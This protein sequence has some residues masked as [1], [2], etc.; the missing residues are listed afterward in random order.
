MEEGGQV[1]VL[2]ALPLPKNENTLREGRVSCWSAT[3]FDPKQKFRAYLLNRP[4][5][6]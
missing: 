5:F 2:C 6:S 3:A 1:L 4:Y